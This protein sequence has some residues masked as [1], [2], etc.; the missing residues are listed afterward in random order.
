MNSATRKL[1]NALK[2]KEPDY[3]TLEL[4]L[5]KLRVRSGNLALLQLTTGL[6][7]DHTAE[8]IEKNLWQAHVD[9]NA[10]FKATL[11]VFREGEARKKHVERRKAE[12]LYVDFIKASQRFYRA[13]IG[14][15][16]AN[17]TNIPKVL[18]VAQKLSQVGLTAETPKVADDVLRDIL[19]S[20][21]KPRGHAYVLRGDNATRATPIQT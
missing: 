5:E 13:Y 16:V 21:C 9:V 7:A 14:R 1:Q 15:L 19:E 17:F 3:S 12:K 4:G 10:K 18:E 8:Q 2:Q 6:P 20:S 11:K